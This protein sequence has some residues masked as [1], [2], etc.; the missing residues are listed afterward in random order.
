MTITPIS[1]PSLAVPDNLISKE[2]SKML[3]GDF[4]KLLAEQMTHQ[5]PLKPMEDTDFIAQ[6][7]NFSALD[8]MKAINENLTDYLKGQSMVG[9]SS[10]VGQY[11]SGIMNNGTTVDGVID[12]VIIK[13]SG[14][15]F[16]IH[17]TDV[18]LADIKELELKNNPNP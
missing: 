1:D 16:R 4:L 7:S 2:D 5:D 8:E 12:T 3:Q 18:P 9:V 15:W 14:T 17:G 6:L 11:A 10:Y 13:D